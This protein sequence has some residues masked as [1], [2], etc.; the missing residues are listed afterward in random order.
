[1]RPWKPWKLPGCHMMSRKETETPIFCSLYVV[2]VS[3]ANLYRFYL[4]ISCT[5]E[6]VKESTSGFVL[7]PSM[8]S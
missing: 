7:Y 3:N 6:Q 2:G 8:T 1:M 5:P 4:P